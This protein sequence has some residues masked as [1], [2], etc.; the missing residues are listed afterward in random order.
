MTEDGPSG[1]RS[2]LLAIYRAAIEAVEGRARVAEFLDECPP[3]GPVHLVAIG[4][5]AAA[6]ARGALDALGPRILRGLVITKHGHLDPALCAEPGIECLEADHPLPG[7]ASLAAGARLVR[8][9]EEAP[10]EAR[11]LFLISGGASALV[12]VLPP[13][14]AP[15]ELERANR[16]LLASGLD[17]TQMNRVRKAIS[18]I[19]AGRLAAHLRGRPVLCL[20]ISD[21]P[22]DDPAVIGSGLLVADRRGGDISDLELPD[23]LQALAA[24]NTA[25]PGNGNLRRVECHVVGSLQEAKTAAAARAVELGYEVSRHRTFLGGDA[26]EAGRACAR[27]LLEEAPGTVHIWGG[28]TTVRLPEHPGRGGR[29]QTLALAAAEELAGHGA[30]WLLAAGT[31]GSDGPGGDAG[32]LVDSGTIERGRAAGLD[33][34]EALARA[35]AGTFLE[36]AGDL[37][38]TGPTGTNVMDLVIGLRR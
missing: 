22:D 34:D 29:S 21:V 20:L 28:E 9:L 37:I 1:P 35:D 27:A 12:E 2:D 26:A 10:D 36:A 19:K 4:K 25:P 11:F 32:A 6:M 5:A 7:P 30:A 17:I 3:S 15:A 38:R 16:W 33:P 14:V 8:F 23:W 24:R 18:A 13:G 31:D